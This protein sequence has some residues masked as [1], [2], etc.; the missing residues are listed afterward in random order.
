MIAHRSQHGHDIFLAALRSIREEQV[1]NQVTNG[2]RTV[3]IPARVD[4][5]IERGQQ[6]DIKRNTESID[7]RHGLRLLDFQLF[8]EFVSDLP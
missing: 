8:S 2:F 3:F 4:V 7:L 6:F 1:T 5:M